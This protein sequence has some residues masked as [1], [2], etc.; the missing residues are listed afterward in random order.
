MRCAERFDC[1]V[2]ACAFVAVPRVPR[3]PR[4]WT[5]LRTAPLWSVSLRRASS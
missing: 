5:H 4:P 1:F 3:A 2:L